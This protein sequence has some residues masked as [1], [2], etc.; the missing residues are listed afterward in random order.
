MGD[1]VEMARCAAICRR[2]AQSCREMSSQRS[3]PA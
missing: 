3:A 1:D 2:C